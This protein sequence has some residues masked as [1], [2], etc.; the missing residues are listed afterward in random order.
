M[1]RKAKDAESRRSQLLFSVEKERANWVLEVDHLKRKQSE[2][3]EYVQSLERSKE[4]MRAEN[5]RLRVD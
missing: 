1:D 2:M 3:D 4:K 5:E